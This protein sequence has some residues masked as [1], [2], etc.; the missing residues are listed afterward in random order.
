M[1]Y[2][3]MRIRKA[4]VVCNRP[5]IGSLSLIALATLFEGA[6]VLDPDR[7]PIRVAL[8]GAA[9]IPDCYLPLARVAGA[10]GQR[11]RARL[12]ALAAKL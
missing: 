1:A 4:G 2:L 10:I 7:C 12:D 8:E 6:T 3:K 5:A 9:I 11:D